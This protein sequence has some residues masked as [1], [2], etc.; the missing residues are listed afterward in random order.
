MRPLRVPVEAG[1]LVRPLVPRMR[2]GGRMIECFNCGHPYKP[3]ASRWMCP[4]CHAKDTC[5]EGAPC[6][7]PSD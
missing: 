7:S 6:P 3:E 1:G 5:C 4:K 2:A